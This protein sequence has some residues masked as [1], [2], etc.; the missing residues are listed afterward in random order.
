M[1]YSMYIPVTVQ[2]GLDPE[3]YQ[4]LQNGDTEAA[5]S[6]ILECILEYAKKAL[7]QEDFDCI[8]FVTRD[9]KVF[10]FNFSDDD[11]IV[12]A[13]SGDLYKRFGDNIAVTF[14]TM[15]ARAIRDALWEMFSVYTEFLE[16]NDVY[17][18]DLDIVEQLQKSNPADLEKMK[19]IWEKVVN[20][21]Y[22]N[23]LASA[24]QAVLNTS[25]GP[26]NKTET[27][28]AMSKYIWIA[29]RLQIMLGEVSDPPFCKHIEHPALWS[30]IDLSD[31]SEE[32]VIVLLGVTV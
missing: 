20:E 25:R 4:K 14:D 26:L 6:K 13:D 2:V 29:R 21:G 30:S 1:E 8:G 31:E 10:K 7:L 9:N 16:D 28:N 17:L 11:E 32:K 19:S 23:I 22:K 15:R 27:Y 18:Y 24:L 3:T 5:C 12:S